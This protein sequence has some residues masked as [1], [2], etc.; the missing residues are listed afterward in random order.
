MGLIIYYFFLSFIILKLPYFINTFV[1]SA[2]LII[3]I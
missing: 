2:L 1:I 3:F